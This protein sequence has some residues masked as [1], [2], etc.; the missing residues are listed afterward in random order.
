MAEGRPDGI[1][2]RERERRRAPGVKKDS[3]GGSTGEKDERSGG[4]V[5]V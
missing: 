4:G 1:Q 3:G 2:G 5:N